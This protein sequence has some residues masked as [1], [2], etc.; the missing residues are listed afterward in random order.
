MDQANVPH[1]DIGGMVKKLGEPLFKQFEKRIQEAI[2][3]YTRA[4]GKPPT[5][6]EVAQLEQH[7]KSLSQKSPEAPQTKARLAAETPAADKLVDAKG[8]PYKAL[9]NPKTGELTTPEK[10]KNYNVKDQFGMEPGNMRAREDVYD[11]AYVNVFGEDPFLSMSNT[12]RMPNRTW[13]KSYTPSTEE[14][15]SRELLGASG[16]DEAME[17]TGGLSRIQ[18]TEGDVPMPQ[19]SP[20]AEKSTAMEMPFVNKLS[21]EISRGE[22]Q[23]LIK[24]VVAE[25]RARGIDPDEEDIL[26]AVNAMIN[27]LR[28]NYTGKNPIGER[29]APPRGRPT[30][31]AESEM[32]RWRDEA[33]ASGLPETVVTEHPDIWSGK[34][35]EDYL[36]DVPEERRAPFSKKWKLEEHA[37][38][39]MVGYANGGLTDLMTN[40]AVSMGQAQPMMDQ[41][42]PMMNTGYQAQPMMN[43]AQPMMNMGYQA[44][45]MMNQ[46]QPMMN[47]AQPMMNMVQ[48]RGKGSRGFMPMNSFAPKLTAGQQ[49]AN[50]FNLTQMYKD[51]IQKRKDIANMQRNAR[52]LGAGVAPTSSADAF[53]MGYQSVQDIPE[54]TNTDWVNRYGNSRMVSTTAGPG[55]YIAN[56]GNRAYAKP[57]ADGGYTGE[58]SPRDMEAEMMVRGY[59]GGKKVKQEYG[60]GRAFLQGLTMNWSDEA[61]AKLRSMMGEG[62][63]D[64]NLAELAAAKQAFEAQYPNLAL[65]SE[66]AGMVPGM[67]VPGMAA[68][69]AP[70]IAAMAARAGVIPTSIAAGA[71]S[72]AVTGAGAAD[73][74]SRMGEAIS[75]G[76]T[77]AGL[78]AGLGLGVKGYQRGKEMLR[79]RGMNPEARIAEEAAGRPFDFR[80]GMKAQSTPERQEWI[81]K[82]HSWAARQND[83]AYQA[84]VFD[85][86]RKAN[87]NLIETTGAQNYDQLMKAAYR[88]SAKETKK[89]FSKI[90]NKV[91]L[92]TDN[93]AGEMDYLARAAKAGMKPAEFMRRELAEGKPFNVYSGGD[94]HPFLSKVDP[95][96]G[97]NENEM[98]RAVHDYF[99]HLGPKTPNSFGPKGEENAWLAHRQMY[100]PLAEPALTAETRG[101]N[102]YVNYVNEINKELRRKGLPTTQY[103]DNVPALLPPEA[104]NPDYVG[105]MPEYLKRIIKE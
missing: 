99:G 82:A 38:G 23:G 105:G 97:L 36:L 34:Y 102:S 71:A 100:S 10:A 28:H 67:L 68:A 20:F 2:R 26:N 12:G 93:N 72:G 14:L 11:P 22:H 57:M 5:A 88:Q 95:A 78:G 69:R 19:T 85:A 27:P 4:T 3:R 31:Q 21:S 73:P 24:Q 18:S 6:E 86:W 63:Y 87:P 70:K 1:F 51:K 81:G 61:E 60:P 8:R 103:A 101:Q 94:P 89:Q 40:S 62:S 55:Y 84:A 52:D 46:A 30:L 7:I 15:A 33:R 48:R 43:Q 53:K 47:Q 41:A 50:R 44:Q 9:P 77:S 65:G 25:F 90:P 42:Q 75:G 29:P 66:I 32:N 37:A 17:E 59:A 92:Y 35:R 74:G 13:Q 54:L 49:N 45:P 58:L 91:Q 16:V 98:F 76:L 80:S 104:S 83:P 56:I 39:G 64:E 79:R 96:T